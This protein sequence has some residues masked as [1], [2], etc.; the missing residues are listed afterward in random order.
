VLRWKSDRCNAPVSN[1]HIAGECE[2]GE[3]FG[4]FKNGVSVHSFFYP[5]VPHLS[6]VPSSANTESINEWAS[7]F[8]TVAND[9]QQTVT[10]L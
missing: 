7:Y 9:M 6:L 10:K 3:V 8:G 5:P 1:Y 4:R 2:Q